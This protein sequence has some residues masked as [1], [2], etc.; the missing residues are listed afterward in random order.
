M[1]WTDLPNAL[2]AFFW[3][4]LLATGIQGIAGIQ[5]RHVP[6]YPA[7]GQYVLYVAFPAIFLGLAALSAFLSRNSRWFY[8]LYPFAVVLLL[9]MSLP[10]LFVWTGGM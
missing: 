7:A 5:E 6:G 3:A 4:L 10:I 2:V 9:M 8:D 1:R